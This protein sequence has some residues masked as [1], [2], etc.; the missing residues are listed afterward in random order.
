M[1]VCIVGAGAIGG[2][3]GARLAL[4]DEDV[5]LITLEPT[6]TTIRQHGIRLIMNDGTEDTVRNFTVTD[7]PHEAGAH[8][9]VILAVKA[10]QIE[11][12]APAVP[13]LSEQDAMVVTVQNGIPWWYF[14]KHGGELDGM[15]LTSLDPNG[16]CQSHIDPDRI[17][18]CIAYPAAATP[19]PGVV[20]HLEG[21]RFPVGELDGSKSERVTALADSFTRAGLRSRVLTDLRGEIWL[22]AWGSVAFNPI[23]ALTRTTLVQICRFPETRAL[24]AAMMR[25]ATDIANKLGISFRHTIERR[26]AGAEAVGDHKTSMLQDVEAGRTLEIEALV[27][28]IVEL[29]RLTNTPT[30]AIDAVYACTKLLNWSLAER[31]HNPTSAST[32]A[33]PA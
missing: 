33:N 25:E 29:G 17:I 6:L 31:Q 20:Q 23:S 14:Q 21:D 16:L 12:V 13:A 5:T 10:H 18:G 15:S 4:A 22:K 24:A 11:S 26:I 9:V 27:G 3:M 19:T 8:D 28:A 1:R 32:L 30:P 7:D 2:F